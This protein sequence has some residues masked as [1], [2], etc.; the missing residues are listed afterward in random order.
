LGLKTL[1]F[2]PNGEFLNI[3]MG[4]FGPDIGI[5]NINI[6]QQK[7]KLYQAK[8]AGHPMRTCSL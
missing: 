1:V 4:P 5:I 6:S 7:E 3:P 2:S 8:L